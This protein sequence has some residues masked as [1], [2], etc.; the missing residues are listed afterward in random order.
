[1]LS[2]TLP[3]LLDAR[4]EVLRVLPNGGATGSHPIEAVSLTVD[5][6]LDEERFGDW[7]ETALG[8]IEARLL[9][10]KGILAIAGLDARVI[11]QG[12]GASIEVTFGAAW[13]D[14]AKTSRLVVLGLG[15]DAES[16]EA[17]FEACAVG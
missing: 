10:V 17:G 1:M 13:G 9:R 3:M 4:A 8:A 6:P 12:V 11:V 5:G 15:L 16:L 7:M 2:Y 14:T